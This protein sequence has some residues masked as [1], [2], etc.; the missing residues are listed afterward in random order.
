MPASV[1]GGFGYHR[2]PDTAFDEATYGVETG[3]SDAKPELASR[4]SGVAVDMILQRSSCRQTDKVIRQRVG[5]GDTAT[6]GKGMLRR[7]EEDEPIFGKGKG[8]EL[9]GRIDGV[10]D[11]TDI[12]R[13]SGNSTYDLRARTLLECEIDVG[14][15]CQE[16]A[17][18]RRQ[19]GLQGCGVGQHPDT[20]AQSLGKDVELSTH[21]F[22][23]LGHDARMMKQGGTGR[24]R[25]DTSSFALE[26]GG[27]QGKLHVANPL[28]CRGERQ[29]A[30][31]G[32]MG[33]A[34]GFSDV[35]YQAQVGE[36][37]SHRS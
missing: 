11:D 2:E 20:A 35:Q 1:G 31:C 4:S 21:Q 19:E 14:V 25:A 37:E 7:S 3:Q 34:R 27:A 30:A 22:Q 16:R 15:S 6:M 29:A 9:E 8:L 5:E 33:D 36:I 13:T 32:T 18:Q 10:S 24:R 28:A 23:L 12:G 17:E 26:Q